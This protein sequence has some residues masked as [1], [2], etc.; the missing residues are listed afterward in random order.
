MDVGLINGLP[1]HP[2][3]VHGAVVLVPLTALVLVV[4]GLWSSA[5]RR[6]GWVLPVMGLVTLVLVVLTTESGEWL[7]ERVR[8]SALVEEHSEMGSGLTP[9]AI[10]LFVLT[11]AAWLLGRAGSRRERDRR[12]EAG[13]PAGH[14]TAAVARLTSSLFV[15]V[16]VLVIALVVAVGA[17]I[18]VYRIADSGAKAAWE[19]RF[20]TS[21]SGAGR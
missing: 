10:A 14:G 11:V 8:E 21:R 6:V 19:G 7:E 5:A 17:V 20:S 12:G 1:G 13:S 2:L 15:R 18:Q 9:W 4:C 16:V 3:F